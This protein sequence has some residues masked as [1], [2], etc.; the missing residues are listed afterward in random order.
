MTH[1]TERERERFMKE[2][3]DGVSPGCFLDDLNAIAI[4]QCI[5]FRYVGNRYH[6]R[7]YQSTD[8]RHTTSKSAIYQ[9][10]HLKALVSL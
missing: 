8:D 7:G 10:R 6:R 4:M 1:D 9:N 2:Q 3:C 5:Y